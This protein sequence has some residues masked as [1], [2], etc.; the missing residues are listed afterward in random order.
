[1]ARSWP[2]AHFKPEQLLCACGGEPETREHLFLH[3]PLYAI[4]H[5]FGFEV[6]LVG[7][8]VASASA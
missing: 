3:Y 2:K 6:R 5:L 8:K 1:M 4:P 7:V